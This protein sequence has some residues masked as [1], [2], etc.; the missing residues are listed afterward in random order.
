M[1]LRLALSQDATQVA[2]N[3]AR[4]LRGWRCL[5]K[6]IKKPAIADDGDDEA[7]NS[8]EGESDAVVLV[9]GDDANVFVESLKDWR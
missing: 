4:K 7:R 3:T 1:Q 8:L 2:A 5:A 6:R 9:A